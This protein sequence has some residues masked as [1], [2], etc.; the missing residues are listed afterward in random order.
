MQSITEELERRRSEEQSAEP[1]REP[2]HRNRTC[3]PHHAHADPQTAPRPSTAELPRDEPVRQ[4][5]DDSQGHDDRSDQGERLRVGQRP[6]QLALGGLHR[7]YR[8]ETDDRR[9]YGGHHGARHFRTGAV[10]DLQAVSAG[11]GIVQMLEDVLG[12]HDAHVDNRADGNGDA[13]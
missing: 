4:R 10:D 11:I 2:R 6:E 8:Q 12:Q 5:R 3:D 9:Q 1:P 13:G 7:E